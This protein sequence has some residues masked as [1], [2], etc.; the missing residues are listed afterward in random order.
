MPTLC[1]GG[2]DDE[3]IPATSVEAFAD[4]LRRAQPARHV[5]MA[6]LPGGHMAQLKK[7]PDAYAALLE[8]LLGDAVP[9]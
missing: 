7:C 2:I 1:I 8:D 9:A 3:M 6:T 4:A 5:K